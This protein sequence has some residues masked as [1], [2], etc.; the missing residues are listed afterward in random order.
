MTVSS[1]TPVY[2]GTIH[3]IS[4][5]ASYATDVVTTPVNLFYSWTGPNNVPIMA[6]NDNVVLS[7]N[8]SLLT[9][10]PVN[11]P[12]I[13]S[14]GYTC[15]VTVDPTNPTYINNAS[16]TDTVSVTVQGKMDCH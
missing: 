2:H 16:N 12:D 1:S 5:E 11:S 9:L 10:S 6:E 7:V 13:S 3:N 15:S 8:N 4:C 14:G